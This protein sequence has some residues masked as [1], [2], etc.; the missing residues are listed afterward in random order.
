LTDAV[1][2]GPAKTTLAPFL[3]AESWPRLVFLNGLH[4]AERSTVSPLPGGVRL[5]SLAEALR[6]DAELVD[7]L[8]LA[9]PDGE[10]IVSH[11]RNLLVLGAGAAA[12][13]IETYACASRDAYWT[14]AVTEIVIGEGARVDHTKML[15]ESE[16]GSHTAM[17]RVALGRDAACRSSSIAL[18]A[19]LARNDLQVLLDAEGGDCTLDG[20][21]IAGEGQHVDNHTL[22]DHAK[23]HG[24]SRELYKGILGSRARAVFNGKVIVRRNAQK[25]DAQQTNKNLLLSERAEVD[26]KPQLE[27]FADDVKCTHGAAIGQLERD[28]IFYCESRGMDLETAQRLLTH[29]FASE[30]IARIASPELRA[31]VDELVTARLAGLAGAASPQR[32]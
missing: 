18:G 9:N 14:N 19:E 21:Y 4:S 5:G 24:T 20:L 13:V 1:N 17:T 25:T 3:V 12:T 23:P 2:G 7:I 16:H 26:T 15:Q 28:A 11:P 27:I 6:S 30:V 32:V 31:K 10:R 8:Y 22:V 29:G